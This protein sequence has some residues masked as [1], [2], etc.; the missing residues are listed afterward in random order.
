GFDPLKIRQNPLFSPTRYSDLISYVSGSGSSF[1]VRINVRGRN[2]N[3]DAGLN[4]VAELR[5]EGASYQRTT[6]WSNDRSAVRVWNLKPVDGL[7]ICSINSVGATSLS[8]PQFQERS[9]ANDHWVLVIDSLEGSGGNNSSL[10]SQLPNI[11]D[12][13]I[14]FSIKGFSN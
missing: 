1:G 14:T 6:K 7:I 2:L 9:A 4:V 8:T 10:L 11:T 3:L 5:Q 13:E 12:L